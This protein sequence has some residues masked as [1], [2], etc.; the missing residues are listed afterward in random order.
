V[1]GRRALLQHR[2]EFPPTGG[3]SKINYSAYRWLHEKAKS[4]EDALAVLEPAAG[5]GGGWQGW[6]ASC[7]N[8][9]RA[10]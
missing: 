9:R 4:A 1:A 7:S 6:K 10:S 5:V 3:F 8:R 2:D